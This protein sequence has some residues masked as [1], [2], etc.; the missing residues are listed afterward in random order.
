MELVPPGARMDLDHGH[1]H[2]CKLSMKGNNEN[3][4]A[5]V[6]TD[7]ISKEQYLEIEHNCPFVI[8]YTMY[9]TIVMSEYD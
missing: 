2:L 1:S 8:A 9:T 7:L 6:F 3:L 4:G 5:G